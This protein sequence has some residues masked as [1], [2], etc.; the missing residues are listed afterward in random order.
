MT[1][2]NQKTLVSKLRN[3]E[4]RIQVLVERSYNLNL[5]N[6]ESR[7]LDKRKKKLS[8]TRTKLKKR[9]DILNIE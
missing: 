3:I 4:N 6:S 2:S 5:N 8:K 9:L 7:E 1:R